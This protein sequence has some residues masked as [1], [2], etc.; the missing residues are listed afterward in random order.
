MI[1]F[2][3]LNMDLIINVLKAKIWLHNRRIHSDANPLL[4]IQMAVYNFWMVAPKIRVFWEKNNGQ[5]RE[6]HN[7]KMLS[8]KGF[9]CS[10]ILCNKMPECRQIKQ[11]KSLKVLKCYEGILWIINDQCFILYLV[12]HL[13]LKLCTKKEKNCSMVFVLNH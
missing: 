9:Q 8:S 13:Q 3:S 10:N 4:I 1:H 2:E 5:W 11:N 6:F 7:V 12:G